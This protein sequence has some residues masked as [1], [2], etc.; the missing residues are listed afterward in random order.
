MVEIEENP[1]CCPSPAPLSGDE[2]ICERGYGPVGECSLEC[3]S[4]IY[5][6]FADECLDYG[7]RSN[8]TVAKLQ[9]DRT[10]RLCRAG[11]LRAG[12]EAL[13]ADNKLAY[14]PYGGLLLF[15]LPLFFFGVFIF[16]GKQLAT[17]FRMLVGG[18]AMGFAIA[19][20]AV[21]PY[22]TACEI[23]LDGSE[24]VTVC[25]DTPDIESGLVISLALAAVTFFQAGYT[26]RQ[27][28][29]F[30]NAVQGFTLGVIF[31]ILLLN[32]LLGEVRETAE[33]SWLI[34]G[35]Y[36]TMGAI[37]AIFNVFLS[38]GVNILAS[39]M[40]G[41]YICC[42]IVC[43]VGY[44]ENWFFTFPVSVMASSMGVS[45]CQDG[46]CWLYLFFWILVG[47]GGC[48]SQLTASETAEKV[49]DGE[50]AHGCWGKFMYM[51]HQAVAMVLD[52]EDAMAEHAE[53]HTAEEM[54]VLAAH[55]AAT[56]AKMA[57]ITSDTCIM[58]FGFSLLAG[59]IELFMR[60]IDAPFSL[61]FYICASAL[62]AMV[63][64][65]Y[66]M[67]I[68]NTASVTMRV[69]KFDIYIWGVFVLV[70][71][72][73]T[74]FLLCLTLGM[75]SDPLGL[76][77]NFG[78]DLL[79]DTDCDGA[80][81]TDQAHRTMFFRHMQASAFAFMGLAVSA[82]LTATYVSRHLGGLLYLA[83]K[84]TKFVAFL[85][86]GYG[87]IFIIIGVVFVPPEG[88]DYSGAWL[89]PAMAVIG[90][91]ECLTGI[92]GIAGAC[93]HAKKGE[94]AKAG[95]NGAAAAKEVAAMTGS[96]DAGAGEEDGEEVEAEATE[97][98][99]EEEA[100]TIKSLKIFAGMLAFI[101]LL[102]LGVFIAA[103]MWATDVATMTHNDWLIINGTH[104]PLQA[105]CGKI[106]EP[107][108]TCMVT[109]EQFEH[110]IMASF[111]LLMAVGITVIVY[112]MVGLG[113]AIFVMLQK[114]GMLSHAEE[115]VA[116]HAKDYL[117]EITASELRDKAG[118]ESGLR[119]VETM[120]AVAAS[121]GGPK[122]KKK[123]KKRV[124]VKKNPD[125]TAE[126][127][128][129][130]KAKRKAEKDAAKT[131]SVDNPAAAAAAPGAVFDVEDGALN[132]DGAGSG[133][134]SSDGSEYEWHT[135]D[136]EEEE[137]EED[138]SDI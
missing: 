133:D 90:V 45:G 136:T 113:A 121:T 55:H 131:D 95:I 49:E 110:D 105:Y 78:V 24:V 19:W 71:V 18:T 84:A 44:F 93:A 116:K 81:C 80:D 7:Y 13:Y 75:E 42:Q 87:A 4:Q 74:G 32:M 85:L 129:E 98:E 97:E 124:K 21:S 38:T 22:F 20:P 10:Y 135:T 48:T 126:E 47:L 31:V 39:T 127:K 27:L 6:E 11:L 73:V 70:P 132:G 107:L 111:Q 112:M 35:M 86:I 101:M 115:M 54:A 53:Y 46:W 9:M 103:G 62:T 79:V 57:T 51:S 72:S 16:F 119:Q 23:G 120:A 114:P 91:I 58:M 125:E 26:C 100:K 102:N 108:E 99:L 17:M 83:L 92:M 88:S 77:D 68:H 37:G 76:H 14:I 52:M 60:G 63:F 40:I 117:D 59:I 30:G 94:K 15:I 122:K 25:T 41:T 8:Q 104:G 96:S 67:S 29:S 1:S 64:T 33:T 128:A 50:V 28:E 82:C 43:I 5:M 34:L 89:Y 69:K 130:R 2:D 137:S 118:K 61:A 109:R 138:L 123:K 134:E 12:A 65:L 106:G 56:W 66:E 36:V 3:A